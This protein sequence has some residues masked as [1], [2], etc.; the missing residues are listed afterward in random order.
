MKMS[1]NLRNVCIIAHVDHGKTTLVDFL[2][3]QAGTFAEHQA[4]DDRVMDSMD[5]ERERGITILAKNTSVVVGNTKINIIDTPGHADFGGEVERVIGMSQGAILLVDAAEGPLPQT[6]FV[7]EKAIQQKL[8]IIL[9]INKVDRQEVREGGRID[10]VINQA[11][12]LFCDLG[13]SEEQTEFPI[14][15]AC[16]RE[17][18]CTMDAGEIPAHL[19]GEK[20]GD[21]R[22]LFDLILDYVNPPAV[23]ND[24]FS[25]LVSNLDYSEWVGQ[26][27]VG[28][29]LSGNVKK[30]DK[31]FCK[32]VNVE[33]QPTTRSFSVTK[34][35]SFSGLRQV[36]VD[37]LEAGDIGLV[38]GLEEVQ[39][40]D[41]LVANESQ[42]AMSR[43]KVEA[44]TLGMIFSIN[45]SPLA[46][47]E[48]EAVQ[49]RKLRDRLLRSVRYNV[50]LRFEDAGT[51]DQF[52]ILGRGELQFAILIEQM[53]REG[54][55]FMVGRPEV[56]FKTDEHGEKVEPLERLVLDLPEQFS[57]EVTEILQTR[58]GIMSSFENIGHGRVRLKFDIPTRGILG[59]NSR[60]KTATRG[61]GLFSSEFIGYVPY[62]GELT[63]R[64]NGALISDR[65]GETNAYALESIQE[66]GQLFVNPG[67]KIYE[68][69]IIGECS[70]D[71]D[72]NVN[73]CREKKLTNV[74]AAGSDGL[75]MLQGIRKMSLE[76][77]IEWIEDD[78]W[79]EVTPE[80]IRIRKKVL[81]ANLR[82]V[83]RGAKK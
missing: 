51:S 19:N 62:K 34:V 44:P 15:Y 39:I 59:I 12:D 38:S 55:E 4:V 73:A 66:R 50:A 33:G 46:G 8:K 37:T 36:E 83:K 18:W 13:A 48:G 24:P 67:V 25:M 21:L 14:V 79:I 82:S 42:Q 60:Y 3:R 78:E 9:V 29:V 16:G 35:L 71:N 53:R 1:L 68:G 28:R 10:E 2:L 5:L 64:I 47:Q 45:T 63:H 57:G 17:G 32:S 70:K 69:M 76:N 58:K 22:P 74:R 6:R 65:E 26:L 40:G 54:L 7:L 49:S 30:G 56:L 31:L 20:T 43:I 27:A 72:L 41:T 52:R 80:S 11:F 61:E 75:I 77:C 23:T 81:A